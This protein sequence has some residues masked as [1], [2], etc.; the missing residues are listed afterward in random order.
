MHIKQKHNYS[1]VL[2]I[3]YSNYWGILCIQVL[4]MLCQHI[5][6]ALTTVSFNV[7]TQ[8]QGATHSTAVWWPPFLH[9]SITHSG[10]TRRRGTVKRELTTG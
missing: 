10:Q 1:I 6:W 7:P 3:M 5:S 2:D 4:G 9:I 8:K